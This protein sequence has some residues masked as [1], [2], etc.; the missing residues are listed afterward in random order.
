[1]FGLLHGIP[2]R[3]ES[4][5]L[6]DSHNSPEAESTAI[7]TRPTSKR[8]GSPEGRILITG[9]VLALM[10]IVWLALSYFASPES[11]Q[12][13]V[14][15]TATHILFGRA[16]GMSFGYALDF[17]HR[18]VIP[19]NLM[20]ETIMVLLFYPLFVFSWR[21][22]VVIDAL[23]SFMQRV[24]RVAEAQPPH[25]TTLRDPGSVPSS[26]SSRSG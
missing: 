19:V 17:G 1:M 7:R 13:V 26:C 15:M 24:K 4:Y 16:A 14:G 6:T 18:V 25:D 2:S 10:Y 3:S 22:L 23:E 12:A 21:H 8:F 9:F 11:F 5:T 20:I